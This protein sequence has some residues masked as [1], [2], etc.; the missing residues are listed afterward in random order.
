[1]R[2]SARKPSWKAIRVT[3]DKGWEIS[4]DAERH[5]PSTLG[6]TAIILIDR[7]YK[8]G[9]GLSRQ[10]FSRR[11]TRT[12]LTSPRFTS[13]STVEASNQPMAIISRPRWGEWKQDQCSHCILGK[14]H[15]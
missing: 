8:E 3:M 14:P 2:V 11:D 9:N 13:F 10:S 1:V 15:Q 5:H 6:E 12:K 4:N 7:P